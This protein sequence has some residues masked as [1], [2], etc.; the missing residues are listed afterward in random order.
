[1]QLRRHGFREG[2]TIMSDKMQV[3]FVKPTGHV[4]AAFTRTAD[5][6][7]KPKVSALA[8]SGLLVRNLT[9]VS[10]SSSE[11]ETLHVESE[12]GETLVAPS[13]SLDVAVV[14]YDQD[15]FDDPRSFVAGGGKV[16]SFGA[17]ARSTITLSR[18]KLIIEVTGGVPSD[19][20]VWAQVEKVITS[21]DS[22]PVTRVMTGIIEKTK[23]KAELILTISPGG[24]AASIPTGKY[25]ILVLVEGRPPQFETKSP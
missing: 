7:D 11:D 3:L 9:T 1:L 5:P 25:Y 8:G 16:E 22:D 4:L 10:V 24:T 6:E 15:V 20:K 19:L 21:T 13:D 12:G 14:D 2:E 17:P 18:D 23:T